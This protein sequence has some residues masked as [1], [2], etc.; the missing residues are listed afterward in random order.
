[1]TAS[2]TRRTVVRSTRARPTPSISITPSR[3]P[4]PARTMRPTSPF[5]PATATRRPLA[6]VSPSTPRAP[7]SRSPTA[8]STRTSTLTAG[9]RGLKT[10]A[11][12]TTLSW[13]TSQRTRK[14]PTP[15][16]TSRLRRTT[17]PG[18]TSWRPSPLR[19]L[20]R[21]APN[22]MRLMCWRTGMR[23]K[24][25]TAS[26]AVTTWVRSPSRLATRPTS[27]SAMSSSCVRLAA[28]RMCVGQRISGRERLAFL[29]PGSLIMSVTLT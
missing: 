15:R 27:S 2:P 26:P 21:R 25:T 24:P 13:V 1:M 7:T 14:S 29:V 28:T 20:P 3:P 11:I 19:T 8:P 17:L 18:R 6:P 9:T 10:L 23:P 4:S 5:L 22:P 12:T 16:R